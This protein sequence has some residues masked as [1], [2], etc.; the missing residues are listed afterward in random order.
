MTLTCYDKNFMADT[1]MGKVTFTPEEFMDL[2]SPRKW[3]SL[4]DK[5]GAHDRARGEVEVN[6]VWEFAATTGSKVERRDSMAVPGVELVNEADEQERKEVEEERKA[7]AE[8]EAKRQEELNNITMK[9]GDYQV[10]V[11]IIEVG[12]GVTTVRCL[13]VC[14]FVCLLAYYMHACHVGAEPEARR[15]ERHV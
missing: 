3:L 13:F 7:A 2:E 11:H 12:G 1:F 9:E 4:V 5:K 15:P 14:L 8:A 6:V 10:Q